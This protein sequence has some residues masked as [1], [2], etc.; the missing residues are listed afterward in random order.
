MKAPETSKRHIYRKGKGQISYYKLK[1]LSTPDPQDRS[2][3]LD[4]RCGKR[5]YMIGI[6]CGRRRFRFGYDPGSL[7]PKGY[8]SYEVSRW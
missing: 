5:H 1:P 8:S 4:L 6:E 3:R 2:Y 7:S